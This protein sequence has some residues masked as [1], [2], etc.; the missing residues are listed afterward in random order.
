MEMLI[1]QTR[2]VLIRVNA[3]QDIKAMEQLVLVCGYIF[4]WLFK[5]WSLFLFTYYIVII[6]YNPYILIVDVDECANNTDICNA[7][8]NCTNSNGSYSCECNTGYEGNGTT[9]DGMWL[10]IFIAIQTVFAIFIYYYIVGPSLGPMNSGSC[11]RAC[12]RACVCP[13]VRPSVTLSRE[14]AH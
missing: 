8:A 9:C 13:S 11:V 5:L 6:V 14:L 3:T 4:L 12:M 1:V 2:M 10:Y 7:D